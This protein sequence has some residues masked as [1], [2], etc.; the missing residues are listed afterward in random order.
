MLD[1][2]II[3][4]S[5]CPWASSAC[6][7]NKPDGSKRFCN[8]YR[9]INN[10]TVQDPFPLPRIED[11]IDIFG[12]AMIFSFMDLKSG[13][14]KYVKDFAKLAL[15]LTKLTKND[16]K[17]D[18]TESC[19]QAFEEFKEKFTS[20]P[21]L[22]A[23]V[24][25]RKFILYTDAPGVQLGAILC[26]KDKNGIEDVCAYVSRPLK[27]VELQYGITEKECLAVV[28]SVKKF[29]IYLYGNILILVIDHS[30]LLWLMKIKEAKGRLARWAICL[31]TYTFEI[32]HRAGK[33]H[34]KAD[35]LS[36]AFAV[37]EKLDEELDTDRLIKE[38]DPWEDDFLLHFLRTGKYLPGS[39]KKQYR[40]RRGMKEYFVKWKGFPDKE[41]SLVKESDFVSMDCLD[42]YLKKKS[43]QDTIPIKR[44]N[45]NLKLSQN[46]FISLA[47]FTIFLP[48]TFCK[49]IEVG[50]SKYAVDGY[51]YKCSKKGVKITTF[52]SFS[53]SRS[54]NKDTSDEVI[55][56]N[57]CLAMVISK[58]CRKNQMIC[59]GDVVSLMENVILNIIG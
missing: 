42:N 31:Q 13:Y 9:Q 2:R 49:T 21:V 35:G 32:V 52:K 4:Q 41:N 11:I 38:L 18:W 12:V 14:R 7:T 51:G 59:D 43:K 48:L 29:R 19:Q 27:G 5:T 58:K 28:W 34:L 16:V 20:F 23:P 17:W 8:D 44:V 55:S 1:A 50:M 33:M 57:E 25:S 39:S 15:P 56:K 45:G 10:I 40:T 26:Q 37:D 36:R 6:L 3:Q 22:R 24:M 53:G 46:L 54:K 30:A 47:L